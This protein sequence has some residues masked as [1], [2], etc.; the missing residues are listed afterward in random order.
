MS[1]IDIPSCFASASS[2][3]SFFQ[4]SSASGP[5][6]RPAPPAHPRPRFRQETRGA[7]RCSQSKDVSELVWTWI[8]VFQCPKKRSRASVLDCLWKKGP[9][10]MLMFAEVMV[11]VRGAKWAWVWAEILAKALYLRAAT[12]RSLCQAPVTLWTPQWG[13]IMNRLVLLHLRLLQ[14]SKTLWVKAVRE[15]KG[16]WTRHS[17]AK[18]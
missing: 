17:L 15:L 11:F 18:K 8:L 12:R 13:D 10:Q 14:H 3:A 2:P 9:V 6:G 1:A 4:S 7:L 5:S 16:R